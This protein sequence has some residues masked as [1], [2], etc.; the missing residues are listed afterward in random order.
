ML[1]SGVPK[2]VPFGVSQETAWSVG[3]SCGG[4]IDVYVEPLSEEEGP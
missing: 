1:A 2:L 3:L 4:K